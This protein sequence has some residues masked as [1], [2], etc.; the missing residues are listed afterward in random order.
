VIGED[1]RDDRLLGA[2]TAHS[3]CVTRRG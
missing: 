3:S 2:A 1:T